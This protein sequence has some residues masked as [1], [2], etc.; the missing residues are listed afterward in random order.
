ML[1]RICRAASRLRRAY[2]GLEEERP[3]VADALAGAV[4]LAGVVLAA[5][6]EGGAVAIP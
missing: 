2:E 6:I 5:G 4:V 3:A 1:L